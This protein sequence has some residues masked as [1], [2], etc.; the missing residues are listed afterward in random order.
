ML[1]LSLSMVSSVFC[2]LVTWK[3]HIVLSLGFKCVDNLG[4]H[5]EKKFPSPLVVYVGRKFPRLSPSRNESGLLAYG[6]SPHY[7]G[8]GSFLFPSKVE[9]CLIVRLVYRAK[10]VQ[11]QSG[12]ANARTISA[13]QVWLCCRL[14]MTR[15]LESFSNLFPPPSFNLSPNLADSLQWLPDLPLFM[16]LVTR[17]L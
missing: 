14:L 17:L 15:S 12:K 4:G 13:A 9:W 2:V 16:S 7:Y 6:V 1:H 5:R 10:Q 11:V 3:I 8:R